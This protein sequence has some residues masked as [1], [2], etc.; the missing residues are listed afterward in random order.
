MLF[1]DFPICDDFPWFFPIGIPMCDDFP[2]FFPFKYQCVMIFHGV[3]QLNTILTGF[4]WPLFF[5]PGAGA[6]H[7]FPG[8][9][10]LISM[11][12]DVAVAAVVIGF[13]LDP[14]CSKDKE[15]RS[16][17][18]VFNV[19]IYHIYTY[20]YIHTYIHTYIYIYIH[21]YIHIY[22]YI[23]IYIIHIYTYIYIHYTNIYIYICICI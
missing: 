2:W 22:I 16:P 1:H 13:S 4:V 23:Y 10:I 15:W 18:S 3:S 6:C 11:V 8:R 5:I 17:G 12:S 14:S 21:T 20:T 19:Y 7:A 9:W